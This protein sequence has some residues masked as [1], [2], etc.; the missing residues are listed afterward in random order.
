MKNKSISLAL[1]NRK[2][3]SASW[4]LIQIVTQDVALDEIVGDQPFI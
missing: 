2:K 4:P 1:V 3:G